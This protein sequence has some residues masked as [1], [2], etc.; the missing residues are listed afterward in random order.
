MIRKYFDIYRNMLIYIYSCVFVV[1][2]V[3]RG[4]KDINKNTIQHSAVNGMF[5]SK[6]FP[7]GQEHIEG[8]AER[9]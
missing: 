7:Q 6:A 9:A 4:N 2:Q 5:P 1:C 3:S 8:E